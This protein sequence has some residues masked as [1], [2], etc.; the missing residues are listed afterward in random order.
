MPGTRSCGKATGGGAATSDGNFPAGHPACE[1][2][3]ESA[4]RELSEQQENMGESCPKDLQD[5]AI[6]ILRASVTSARK[7]LDD[8]TVEVN[9]RVG[10]IK[11]A[12]GRAT[13][14]AVLVQYTKALADS[15]DKGDQLLAAF[16]TKNTSLLEKMELLLLKLETSGPGQHTRVESVRNKLVGEALPYQGRFRKLWVEYEDLL[17]C[18]WDTQG[19]S[20]IAEHG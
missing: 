13:P 7:L 11:A 3:V 20:L 17:S 9:A 16:T 18:L 19:T 8:I 14:K 10:I 15:F 1:F 4:V 6:R 12:K 2:D 5:A